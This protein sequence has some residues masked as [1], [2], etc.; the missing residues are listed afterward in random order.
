MPIDRELE[1]LA[2]RVLDKI[3]ASGHA[4]AVFLRLGRQLRI[5]RVGRDTDK[6]IRNERHNFVGIFDERATLKQI[7]EDIIATEQL[8]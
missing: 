3:A 8:H 2:L 6:R 7:L 1:I 5:E 4:Q